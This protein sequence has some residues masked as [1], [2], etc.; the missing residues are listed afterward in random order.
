MDK[1]RAINKEGTG[2]GLYI[3]Q[4]MLSAHGKDIKVESVEGEYAKFTFCLDKG[5]ENKKNKE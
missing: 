4:S 2:I 5:K 1:S 3:V